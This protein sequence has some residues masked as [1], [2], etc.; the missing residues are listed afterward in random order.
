[1]HLILSSLF[2]FLSCSS[3]GFAATR[4]Y[5]HE[6]EER[7]DAFAPLKRIRDEWRHKVLNQG[8]PARTSIIEA[9]Q[10]KLTAAWSSYLEVREDLALEGDVPTAEQMVTSFMGKYRHAP[11]SEKADGGD[12]ISH[13][14]AE[15]KNY[16]ERR[17]QLLA[18]EEIKKQKEEKIARR[19]RTSSGSS[20]ASDHSPHW[21]TGTPPKAGT[22]PQAS[23]PP[24]K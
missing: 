11:L 7:E 2:V 5:A 10:Y 20:S 19:R 22:S 6:R 4:D 16:T 14:Y 12:L 13:V 8:E 15:W 3:L 21:K 18:E 1:M 24:K 23:T 17:L 9:A